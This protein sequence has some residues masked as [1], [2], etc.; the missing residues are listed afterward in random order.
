MET[1]RIREATL[2]DL[3]VLLDLMEAFNVFERIP[4]KRSTGEPALRALLADERL[5]L[6]GLV[7][8]DASTLGY[9]I[10]TWGY[11]LEW[12][13]RDAVLT[14]LF[15][16]ENA[17][18]RGVGKLVLRRAESL[19]VEHGAHALHLMVRHDNEPAR[20]LY[21]GA[22]YVSPPRTFLTKVLVGKSP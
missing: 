10:V 8:D 5:G 19:A 9:F 3:G 6:V 13:G 21:Q 11:D 20:R 18:G 2:G 17:R 16:S 14:E 22:G 12:N 7:E 1:I 4:W 15:L